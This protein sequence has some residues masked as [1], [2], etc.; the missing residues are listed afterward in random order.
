MVETEMSEE[1][2]NSIPLSAKEQIINRHPLGLGKSE[3][4]SA[5]TC[6]LL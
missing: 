6:F 1:I 4:L 3:D 5:L 2:F